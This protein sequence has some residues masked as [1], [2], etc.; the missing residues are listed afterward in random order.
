MERNASSGLKKLRATFQKKSRYSEWTLRILL[1]KIKRNPF[2]FFS[3]L[4]KDLEPYGIICSAGL[5]RRIQ[6]QPESHF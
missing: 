2:A 1:Q 6:I 5:I 3:D 4:K